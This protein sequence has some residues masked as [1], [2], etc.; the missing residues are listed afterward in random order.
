M[1]KKLFISL[2]IFVITFAVISISSD[3]YYHGRLT[4]KQSHDGEERLCACDFR[5]F[6]TAARSMRSAE[7]AVYDK[8]ETFYHFRYSP[9]GALVMI[10]Y[11]LIGHAPLALNVWF[12]TLNIAMLMALLLLVN[13]LSAS[14]NIS[15]E[16]KFIILWATLIVSLRFYLMSLAV[17]QIDVIIALLFVF[18]LLAYVRDKELLSGVI[19]ALILQFK[20]LFL[21]ACFYFLFAGKKKLVLSTVVAFFAFLF[22]PVLVVGFEQTAML[23]KN[24]VAILE[25]S[26]PSQ[27]LNYK[28]QSITYFIG[29]LLLKNEA[30]EKLISVKDLFYA[31]GGALTLSAYIL[32]LRFKRG[33]ERRGGNKYKYVEVSG[34]ILV[35]LLFSPIVWVAHFIN[36]IIPFSVTLLFVLNS[37][38]KKALYWALGAFFMLSWVIGTDI[39]NFIPYVNKIHFINIALGTIFLTYALFSSYRQSTA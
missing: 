3:I 4:Y 39:T 9:F 22:I 25:I 27:L 11:G 10:P 26:V 20:P 33:L 7:G 16:H 13:H 19:L 2:I 32:M 18:F 17:G 24:W 36:L 23:L 6:W 1:I 28:N 31:L 37:K 14:F 15:R 29:N 34:V 30:L 21:P 12:I 35:T 5:V 8:S 38:K